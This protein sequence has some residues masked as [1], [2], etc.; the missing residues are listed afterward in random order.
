M[1]IF[2]QQNSLGTVLIVD[3][4][5]ENLDLLSQTLT[6][7]GYQVRCA[8]NGYLALMSIKHELPDL[9]LL[10]I[11]MPGM[12][13]YQVCQNLKENY[14]TKDIPIIF[15]SSAYETEEKI[16]A[17]AV[18]GVDYITKPF[19]VAEVLARVNTQMGLLKTQLEL[20][21]LNQELEKRI[22]RRTDELERLNQ[23]LR[24]E[25]EERK[26]IQEKLI[27]DALHDSLT[28]LPNRTLFIDR[29]KMLIRHCHRFPSFQFAILFIDLDRFKLIN[30]SLGH[31]AGDRLLVFCGQL[32]QK[33]VRESD[34]VARLGGD[35]FGILLDNI[36]D[37]THAIDTAETIKMQLSKSSPLFNHHFS[38]SA[39]IGI[40]IGNYQCQNATDL[41][42][43]ADI[44]MYRAKEMGKARYA[45]FNQELHQQAIQRLEIESDLKKALAFNEMLV[46]YQPIVELQTKRLKGFECLIRWQ[47]PKKGLISPLEFIPIAEECGLI[48]SLGDWVLQESCRQ[49]KQWQTR[50]SHHSELS[51]NVNFSPK[52]FE[53]IYLPQTIHNVLLDNELEPHHLNIEITENVFL[54]NNIT[55]SKILSQLDKLQIPISLDDFG[56]GY[57]S[58]SYLHRFPI[59]VIKIDGSFIRQMQN[60]NKYLEIVKTITTLGHT[61]GMKIIAE[62]IETERQL[63]TLQ[64]LG[65]EFGQGYFFGKPLQ[66]SVAEKLI[67][68][69]NKD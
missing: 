60:H 31:H 7:Q 34:T 45:I 54:S 55:V 20:K 3:D 47:H 30:D 6:S 42:R 68:I 50:Y 63:H 39:S 66:A 27:Y 2:P 18:G 29:V 52:Q 8:K 58:L 25:N 62:G 51:I 32:F 67:Q 12:N 38:P 43:N 24:L 17:F 33:C 22:K 1:N 69:S 26:K 44:A 49:L 28:N 41:L 57:S 65:C 5:L 4:V 11:K 40:V 15:L 16:Q 36:S 21:Q 37:V 14:K 19:E 9:I 13:G 59:S 46:Y 35:E 48:S 64:E 10:D 53:D 56:T 23:E 61:L